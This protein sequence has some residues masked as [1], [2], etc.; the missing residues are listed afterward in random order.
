MTAAELAGVTKLADAARFNW[1][2]NTVTLASTAP[3]VAAFEMG[4][5]ESGGLVVNSG[6]SLSATN[7]SVVGIV[8]NGGRVYLTAN[9]GSTWTAPAAL[10]NNGSSLSC[11]WFVSPSSGQ[12]CKL[13]NR[14]C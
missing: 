13:H 3:S 5:D 6:G 1:G 8:M 10:P 11:I 7:A 4:V 9:A 2:S 14:C 12:V